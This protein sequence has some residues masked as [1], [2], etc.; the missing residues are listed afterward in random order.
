M[1]LWY[2]RL[3]YMKFHLLKTWQAFQT[4]KCVVFKTYHGRLFICYNSHYKIIAYDGFLPC[5]WISRISYGDG[6]CA[7]S[8][9]FDCLSFQFALIDVWI[10]IF[11]LM[12]F[13]LKNFSC[14]VI[15]VETTNRHDCVDYFVMYFYLDIPKRINRKW[16]WF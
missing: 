16:G 4:S 10:T 9:S 2:K 1:G 5:I 15:H 3:H 7:F 12:F 14:R 8:I 11:E 13:D 6:L